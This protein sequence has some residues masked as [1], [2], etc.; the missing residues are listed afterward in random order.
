MFAEG[1]MG[2]RIW[3]TSG[4]H[5]GGKGTYL[6]PSER[7]TF[8]DYAFLAFERE[9]VKVFLPVCAFGANPLEEKEEQSGDGERFVQAGEGLDVL[10]RSVPA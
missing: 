5:F 1:G 4:Q 9:L 6:E 2:V 3:M 8:D 7:T 10:I